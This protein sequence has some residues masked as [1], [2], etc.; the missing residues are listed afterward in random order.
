METPTFA[1]NSLRIGEK[2]KTEKETQTNTITQVGRICCF[3]LLGKM[4]DKIVL[5]SRV[6][7][8]SKMSRARTAV[9]VKKVQ[10]KKT[11]EKFYP[12]E[13][14]FAVILDLKSETKILH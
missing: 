11:K 12:R 8:R 13:L 6:S 3:I 14:E 1:L 5:K 10:Q 7:R 9:H 4:K 2:T